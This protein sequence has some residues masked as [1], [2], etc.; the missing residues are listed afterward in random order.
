MNPYSII[1]KKQTGVEHSDE[2]IKHVVNIFTSGELTDYQMAA[3]LMAVYFKGM[4]TNETISYTQTLLDSGK[5]LDFSHLPGYVIDKHSTGGV[6]DKVSLILGPI[7]AACGCYVPMISG[8]GLGHTGGTV[9]KLESIPGYQVNLS[10]SEFQQIVEETGISIMGQT[11]DICPADG[12]I[13]ALRDVTATVESEP[14][15]CGSILSKKLAEGITG[16]VMDIKWGN[17]A[18]MKSFHRAEKLGNL[19][20]TVGTELGLKIRNCITGMHQPLGNSCGLWCEV[21]ESVNALRGNGPSDLMDVVFHL[22]SSALEL[23]EISEPAEKMKSVITNGTALDKF[24]TM[25]EHHSGNVDSIHSEDIHQ[26]K[27][28][29]SL[30]AQSDGLIQNIETKQIGIALVELGAGRK[31]QNDILDFSAGIEFEAKPGV[32]IQSGDVIARVFCSDARKLETGFSMVEKAIHIGSDPPDL[33]PLIQKG[34][35]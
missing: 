27:Y 32:E 33:L 35:F 4:T 15:I 16:L 14:L 31:Q 2:E 20:Q 1:Q 30:T 24:N 29:K 10:L 5:I 8:R 6:G 9:D 17:G 7:L 12:K 34:D 22:G 21:Q 18:F 19:I 13:Y 25:V 28:V 26:P 23:A 3:W 11:D